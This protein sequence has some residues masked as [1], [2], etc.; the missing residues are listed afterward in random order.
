MSGG[1]LTA[2]NLS[3]GYERCPVISG[4]T[5][6]IRPG[7]VLALIGPNGSGKTTLLHT[8]GRLLAP[9]E[10]T[11]RLDGRS[12]W[13]RPARE[14]ARALALAPQRAVQTAW[15]LTVAEAVALGRA[16]HRGWLLPYTSGDH[17]SVRAAMER[18]GVSGLARRTV[19]TLSGGEVRRVLLARALAQTPRIMLLDEP[20]T[21]LDLHYQA[22]L[23]GLVRSLAREDGLAVVLTL[24]D[25]ALVAPCADR[26]AL[27]ADGRLRAVGTPAEVLRPEVLA[28]VYGPNLEV[29][30]HPRTG[31]PLVLPRLP[32]GGPG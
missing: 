5:L 11:V 13:E 4:V 18:M 17:G 20:A 6:S 26:V 31:D 8:L 30:T 10:G 14:V 19:A 16:P 7:E 3:C 15:P 25:L 23:L 29:L 1:L 27:L 21:Y 9:I 28:P 22:E 32:A 2:E 12:I 24:H